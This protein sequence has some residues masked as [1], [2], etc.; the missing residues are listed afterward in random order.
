MILAVCAQSLGYCVEMGCFVSDSVG[1]GVHAVCT[2]MANC[3]QL[4]VYWTHWQ[5]TKLCC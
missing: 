2:K 4:L 1:Y 5:Y 3:M